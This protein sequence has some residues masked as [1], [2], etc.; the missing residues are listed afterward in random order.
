M[1]IIITIIIII[2][3]N[4]TVLNECCL[5]SRKDRGA[6]VGGGSRGGFGKKVGFAMCKAPWRTVKT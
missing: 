2:I 4:I 1:C 3:I 6:T 5:F